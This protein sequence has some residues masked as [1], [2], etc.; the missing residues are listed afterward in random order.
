[1]VN[2]QVGPRDYVSKQDFIVV[3]GDR[4]HLTGWD[5]RATGEPGATPVFIVADISQ[6]GHTLQLRNRNGEPL[7]TSPSGM[8]GQ[9][10]GTMDPAPTSRTQGN[11]DAVAADD[12][13]QG[14]AQEPNE[15]NK[16]PEPNKP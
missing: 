12:D 7:W 10:R 3:T 15:P 5:A 13:A 14:S 8:S 16:P 2:V 9:Q 6:D 11:R 1:M 4:V